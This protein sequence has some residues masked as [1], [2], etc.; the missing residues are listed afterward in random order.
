[1]GSVE[2]GKLADQVLWGPAFFGTKPSLIFK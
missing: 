2:L 1:V